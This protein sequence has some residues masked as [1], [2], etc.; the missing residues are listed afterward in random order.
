MADFGTQLKDSFKRGDGLIRL[1]FVNLGVFLLVALITVFGRLFQS[2]LSPF[3]QDVLALPSNLSKLVL[4][5]WTL[6]T[7]MFYHE[8]F[9]H[10]LFNMIMLYFAG[11]L[12]REFLGT[13][14]LVSYYL[15]GGLVGGLLYIAFYNLFPLF[16][17][18]RALSNNRGAS[19]GIMAI[20][21]AAATFRPNLPIRLFFLLEVRLWIVAVLFVL[22]DLLNMTSSNAGG[23]IAHLGGALFGYLAMRQYLKGNDITDG[24]SRWLNQLQSLF[25]AKPKIRKVYTN[26]KHAQTRKT[27]TRGAKQE[28]RMDDILD[29]ISRSG[30]DSLSKEEKDF[31]F[32]IG[33]D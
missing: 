30:Y 31:L 33:K 7:Y 11:M 1:I 26:T 19:A 5:P 13:R 18:V 24:F 8:D 28:Q 22:A 25:K 14:K 2:D 20:V 32:K 29:K 3:F 12:F 27:A 23:H 6:V 16:T 10:I 21:I 17:E 15:L 4:R 9:F